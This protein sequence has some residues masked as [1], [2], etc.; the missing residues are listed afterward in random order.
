[1]NLDTFRMTT[2]ATLANVLRS[3]LA[4]MMGCA[5]PLDTLVCDQGGAAL[6][7]CNASAL[8]TEPPQLWNVKSLA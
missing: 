4:Q 2:D 1:V 5:V 7:K 3:L 6:E 8:Q